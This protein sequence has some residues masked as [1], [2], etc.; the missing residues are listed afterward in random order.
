MAGGIFAI[1][2]ALTLAE[3]EIYAGDDNLARAGKAT[4][5]NVAAGGE[6]GRA[7]D[8]NPDPEYGKNS[9]SG[10]SHL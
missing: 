1:C 6:P 4:Q 8:G 2:G 10:L 5:I 7:I 3:V 9:H